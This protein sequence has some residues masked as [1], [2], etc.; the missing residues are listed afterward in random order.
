MASPAH[1]KGP[2]IETNFVPLL[3]PVLPNGSALDHRPPQLFEAHWLRTFDWECSAC[4]GT[5]A[6]STMPAVHCQLPYQSNQLAVFSGSS[7]PIDRITL[8]VSRSMRS[9]A[10]PGSTSCSATSEQG[11]CRRQVLASEGPERAAP[12][13]RAASYHSHEISTRWHNSLSPSY[14]APQLFEAQQHGKHSFEFPVEMHSVTAEPLQLVRVER[15]TERLLP[16]QGPVLQF[17]TP[18]LEPRQHVVFE[19]TAQGLGVGGCR[20]LVL[21]QLVGMARQQFCPPLPRILAS[22]ASA[23]S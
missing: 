8:C 11:L 22:A 5:C 2:L 10:S 4:R 21:F 13:R 7:E 14:I 23:A 3:P 19:E 6:G 1:L 20:R 9:R 17:L 15:L 12:C 18:C 16:D